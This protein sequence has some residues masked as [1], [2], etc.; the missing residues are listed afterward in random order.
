MQIRRDQRREADGG[1]D[2][3]HLYR[4]TRRHVGSPLACD[5][6]RPSPHHAAPHRTSLPTP[7]S[8][9]IRTGVAT[10][11][12]RN[13]A[14]RHWKLSGRR[15]RRPDRPAGSN[16]ARKERSMRGRQVLM[17]TL[18]AHGVDYLFGNPGTTE[19]PIIDSLQDHPPIRYILALHEAVA[20]GA[21][22][23]Y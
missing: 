17:D 13:R 2:G 11:R 19:S 12:R 3:P 23:Y 10:S 6:L 8:A 4:V 9:S 15:A 14:A 21:A 1:R 20:I 7:R 16:P 22:S 5:P 18:V